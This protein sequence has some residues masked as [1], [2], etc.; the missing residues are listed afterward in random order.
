MVLH[1]EKQICKPELPK[2]A[3][4]HLHRCHRLH[5]LVLSLCLPILSTGHALE[6]VD[7]LDQVQTD[8]KEAVSR[9]TCLLM[10]VGQATELL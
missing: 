9:Q 3:A 10:E 1:S 7:W 5:N 2:P 6:S 8:L 4:C